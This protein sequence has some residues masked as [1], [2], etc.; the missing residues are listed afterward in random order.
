M[1]ETLVEV[2]SASATIEGTAKQFVLESQEMR[3][4]NNKFA[5]IVG[6]ETAK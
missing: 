3:G 6:P 5:E 1:S 4:G 2:R